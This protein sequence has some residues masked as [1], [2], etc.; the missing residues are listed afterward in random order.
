MS[1]AEL[2]SGPSIIT[3]PASVDQNPQTT[4][5]THGAVNT[6][7]EAFNE[8][9]DI[10]LSSSF[11]IDDG[12]RY[13]PAKTKSGWTIVDSHMIFLNFAAGMGSSMIFTNTWCFDGPII[14][15]MSDM[16]G[17]FEAPSS[18]VLGYNGP[19]PTLYPSSF[20]FRGMERSSSADDYTVRGNAIKVSLYAPSHG[21]WLRVIT[22]PSQSHGVTFSIDGSSV[23]I[24]VPDSFEKHPIGPGD[25]L[26]VGEPKF[27]LP[28]QG[29]SSPPFPGLL[30]SAEGLGLSMD[31]EIDAISFGRDG[32]EF[33]LFS[34]DEWAVGCELGL[35][36]L[37]D[38]AVYS[39]GVCTCEFPPGSCTKPLPKCE[40]SADVFGYNRRS[41]M[42][43]VLHLDG[44]GS[45][46]PGIGL[47][48]P[49]A[50]RSQEGDDLDAVDL[51]TSSQD[52]GGRVYFSLEGSIV[53]MKSKLK[54]SGSA[55][56]LGFSAADIL[57]V[58][59][60][61][62]GSPTVYASAAQ[63]GL[64]SEDDIDALALRDDGDGVFD[65]LEDLIWFSV[66][67]GSPII[68]T[69]ACNDSS[70]H[71]SEGDVLTTH[72]Q[73]RK[74]ASCKFGGVP[75]VVFTKTQLGLHPNL[76]DELDA[77]DCISTAPSKDASAG[78]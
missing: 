66:R 33:F 9:Q 27:H 20:S 70:W 64:G 37:A 72:E 75:A 77:L 60:C 39:E 65:P 40:A 32:G 48:E 43:V 34:V 2:I 69:P 51:R 35:G 17:T 23:S 53:D 54:G 7:P 63:L 30:L 13:I 29:R 3:P 56:D 1:H 73:M 36:C 67:R 41:G 8:G 47:I 14:G 78:N 26:T 46:A 71:I 55:S 24:G 68:G 50:P 45:D 12:G 6:Q 74:F 16:H 19:P 15:V 4:T 42:K 38:S 59:E 49:N 76:S 5:G 10:E 57:V 62:I 61:S 31:S 22:T 25:I 18:S 21:D 52:L 58:D 11:E 28:N 44:D